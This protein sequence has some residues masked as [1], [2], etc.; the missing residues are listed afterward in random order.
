MAAFSGELFTTDLTLVQ[1]VQSSALEL[2]TTDLTLVDG[3]ESLPLELFGYG[4]P[5]TAV[6]VQTTAWTTAWIALSTSAKLDASASASS[7]SWS[8]L[9]AS[10]VTDA[11]LVPTGLP[12]SALAALPVTDAQVAA[13]SLSWSALAAQPAT[14]AQL[15]A[16]SL[17]WSALAAQPATDAQLAAASLSWSALAAQPEADAQVTSAELS[18]APVLVSVAFAGAPAVVSG[19]VVLLGGPGGPAVDIRY[20]HEFRGKHRSRPTKATPLHAGREIR[21]TFEER[22]YP[23]LRVAGEPSPAS[24]PEAR[25][26]SLLLGGALVCAGIAIGYLLASR[27]RR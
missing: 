8:V 6:T 22:E 15:A 17:S 24:R 2:F 7:L 16:A 3:V 21:Y 4:A 5:A 19:P 11:S 20:L 1:G 13:A 23:L 12:W 9:A 10:P 26:S 18:W 25:P 14:A 27:V